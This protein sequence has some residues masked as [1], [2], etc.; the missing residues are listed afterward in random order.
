MNKLLDEALEAVRRLPSDSQEE[1]ARAMLHLAAQS[2]EPEPIA[3]LDRRW[4][5]VEA[6]QATVAN[7]AVLQWL[8][9]WGTPAFKR[10]H[11]R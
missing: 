5:K 11:E 3:E 7:N 1:I 8:E 2:E 6:G 4:A 10:W 9:T